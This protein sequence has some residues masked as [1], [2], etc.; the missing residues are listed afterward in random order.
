M[1]G[2]FEYSNTI[3]V[4]VITISSYSLEQNFPNPFNP[5]T[6]INYGLKEKG[7]V[8]ITLLNSIGEEVAILVNEEKDKGYHKVEFDG[9]KLTSGVYFYKLV[10][11]DFVSTKKM[12]LQ[13]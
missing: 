5:S 1:N 8:R 12:I 11:K 9:S 13:K 10:A 4:E 6:T 3:E 7:D 2:E